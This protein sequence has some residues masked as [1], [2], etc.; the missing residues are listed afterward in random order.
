[1]RA[2]VL[3][4]STLSTITWLTPAFSVYTSAC[5]ACSSSQRPLAVLPVKSMM[6]TSG[7][8]ARS[9][10]TLLPASCAKS[11]TTLGSMPASA[12]TSRA[13]FTV[14]ASGRIAPGCGL[15]ITA[16]PVARLAKKPV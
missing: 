15:T 8:N 11:V 2:T 14:I 9:C 3:M 5:R 6:R 16:L 13:I 1:M 4:S 10:A 12:S 7:R